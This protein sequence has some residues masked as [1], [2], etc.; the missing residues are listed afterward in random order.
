MPQ[1]PP[2][3][4]IN[5]DDNRIDQVG[6]YR[7]WYPKDKAIWE[8]GAGEN[9]WLWKGAEA[10]RKGGV[11]G[12]SPL[13]TLTPLY[14]LSPTESALSGWTQGG[15]G[16]SYQ[17]VNG[18]WGATGAAILQQSPSATACT[19]TSDNTPEANQPFW[20]DLYVLQ[21]AAAAWYADFRFSDKFA[22]RFLYN[23][24][25][26][27]WRNYKVGEGEDDW[28]VATSGSTVDS[29][30]NKHLRIAV[31][32]SNQQLLLIQCL[33]YEPIMWIEPEPLVEEDDPFTIRT[34]CPALAPYLYV[35]SGAFYFSYRY[36]TFPE[37]GVFTLPLQQLPWEYGGSWSVAYDVEINRSG[38][39]WSTAYVLVDADGDNLASPPAAPF[40]EFSPKIT[41]TSDGEISPELYWLD[42][43][44][45]PTSKVHAATPTAIVAGGNLLQANVAAA[46][47]GRRAANISLS[48]LDGKYDT[49]ATRMYMPTSIEEDGN[50]VWSGYLQRRETPEEQSGDT[51]VELYGQDTLGRLDLPLSDSYIGDGVKHTEFVSEL[52][53]RAGL[54]SNDFICTVSATDSLLPAA[55]GQENPNFQWRDGQTIRRAIEYIAEVHSGY[56]LWADNDGVIHYE[57]G[58]LAAPVWTLIG[59]E[60]TS[61]ATQIQYY[62]R[63]VTADEDNFYNFITV[64]GQDIRGEPIAAINYDWDSVSNNLSQNYIGYEKPLVLMDS[65]LRSE[66]TVEE[67]LDLLVDEY[68]TPL[69]QAD[70]RCAWNVNLDLMQ[71]VLMDGESWELLSIE[72]RWPKDAQAEMQLH[73]KQEP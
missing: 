30:F 46:R 3:I 33:N 54:G 55:I 41:F 13:I 8:A 68:G 6:F 5:T 64:I 32:P 34:I 35:S 72:H 9:V 28:R 66:A 20:L 14:P 45:L 18:L 4:T 42:M 61:P 58:A 47:H 26:Q 12:L 53:T 50:R 39:T 73:I 25:I 21:V 65:S 29:V 11:A 1:H 63:R 70:V 38:H 51:R 67:A 17:Q 60:P 37:D 49:L 36:M 2:T 23:G 48:N 59:R 31:Y 56:D 7:R 57:S 71:T 27:L 52:L 16:V 15:T 43:Q 62:A 40:R 44:I 24:T 19:L 10:G 69:L 22:L